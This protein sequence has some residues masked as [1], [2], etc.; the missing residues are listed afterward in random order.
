MDQ[1]KRPKPRFQFS[2]KLLLVVLLIAGPLAGLV[3]IQIKKYQERQAISR[4]WGPGRWSGVVHGFGGN[5]TPVNITGKLYLELI[6]RAHDGD[7]NVDAQ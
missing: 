2:L 7:E 4:K 3:G 5:E 1:P 6:Q